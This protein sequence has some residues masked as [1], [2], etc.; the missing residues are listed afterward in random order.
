V[1]DMPLCTLKSHVAR[2][3][4]KLRGPLASYAAPA[5]TPTTTSTHNASNTAGA[6]ATDW[7]DDVL[8]Q[9]PV[10][11]DGFTARVV[12]LTG[13]QRRTTALRAIVLVVIF[14]LLV[15][16]SWLV[17]GW[18]GANAIE[19]IGWSD[20]PAIEAGPWLDA[21][22]AQFRS[23]LASTPRQNRPSHGVRAPTLARSSK[24]CSV[25][26]TPHALRRSGRLPCGRRLRRQTRGRC[27]RW[28]R[29]T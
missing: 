15:P 4:D 25:R 20:N 6:M 8:Q 13:T 27:S 3:K 16:G 17:A 9:R 18:M 11:D 5:S 29:S 23:A 24:S 14:L 22:R 10:D 28:R 2:A 26:A 1:L 7:L 21:H 12:R 19:R